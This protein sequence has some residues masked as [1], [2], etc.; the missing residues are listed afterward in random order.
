MRRWSR[1][2]GTVFD[3][4]RFSIHDGPGIRT[5]VFLKG[6]SLQCFWCHN[7]EGIRR[8]P[9]IQFEPEKCIGCGECVQICEH[10]A[11]FLE[12]GQRFYD[13]A[14]CTACGKCVETCYAGGLTLVG[15]T[16]HVD[17]VLAEVLQDVAFYRSSGGGV[18]FSGGEPVLPQAGLALTDAFAAANPGLA[19]ALQEALEKAAAAVNAEPQ[20]A[21]VEAA[22]AFEL[23]APVI[24]AS[25]PASNLVATRASEARP[26]IEAMLATLSD[27]DPGLIGGRMPDD[28]FYL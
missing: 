16:M 5:T 12:D 26:Q 20:Q 15:A 3:I 19:D 24:A 13:R 4:Q 10:N 2:F 14:A 22:D 21:A 8:Q 18:T 17:D 1:A 7:P 23:P 11:Q 28:G 9:E 25:I 27:A 6:C